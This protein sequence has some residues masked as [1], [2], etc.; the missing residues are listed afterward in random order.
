MRL[1]SRSDLILVLSLVA[2][3]GGRAPAQPVGDGTPDVARQLPPRPAG[4]VDPDAPVEALTVW[5]TG[6]LTPGDTPT[7]DPCDGAEVVVDPVVIDKAVAEVVTTLTEPTYVEVGLDGAT[8]A[9]RHVG[10][11]VAE[12]HG[13]GALDGLSLRAMGNEPFWAASVSADG[14][15]VTVARPMVDEVVRPVEASGEASGTRTYAGEGLT[16]TVANAR[17]ADTMAQAWYPFTATLTIDD[18]TF[19]GCA[20]GLW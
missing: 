18:A 15:T 6:T 12:G 17:C 2:A 5:L 14:G 19:E 4:T 9:V 7:F 16:L 20:R 3:C 11:V 10:A 1:R 8:R 13:C